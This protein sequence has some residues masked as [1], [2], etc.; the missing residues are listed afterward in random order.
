MANLYVPNSD[1]TGIARIYRGAADLPLSPDNPDVF[2]PEDHWT[3]ALAEAL[4][5]LHER[6][7]LKDQ[8]VIELG[9]GSGVNMLGLFA[10]GHYFSQPPSFIGLD[11]TVESVKACKEL[12]KLH[13]FEDKVI[14]G[15]ANLMDGVDPAILEGTDT[16]IACLP[17]VAWDYEDKGRDPLPREFSDYYII[18]ED[19][20]VK[21][22][23]YALGLL[24]R[25]LDQIHEKTPKASVI[26]NIAGRQGQLSHDLFVEHGFPN[27]EK[28]VSRIIPHDPLTSLT[29]FSKWEDKSG[30]LCR[31][32][33][34][35]AGVNT[36]SAKQAEERRVAGQP[37]YHELS[38]VHASPAV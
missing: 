27:V 35:E 3:L 38:V 33:T 20:R 26:F 13:G 2:P 21:E 15:Q 30:K 36:I 23:D 34:D 8:K 18:P 28:V 11:I 9:A 25:A 16:V 4:T 14:L 7:E 22:D 32:F 1:A 17:L 19:Q 29:S 31:F 5:R 24:A 12:A 37:L 6:G 10:L